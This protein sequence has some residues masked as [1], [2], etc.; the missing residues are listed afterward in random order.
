MSRSVVIDPVTR[1]EGRARVTIRLADD[2]SVEDA[3]VQV[4]DLR[5]FEALCVGRPLSEMPALTARVCGICPVSHSLAAAK[6]GD[7]I[8]GADPPPAARRLRQLVQFA[9]LV[10][11][12]A[13]SFFYLSVPDFVVGHDGDPAERSILGVARALPWLAQDGV[14][15]RRFGQEVIAHAAGQRVHPA[16]AVPGGVARPLPALARERILAELPAAFAAAERALAWW[17]RTSSAL[18]DDA[19]SCGNFESA[20]LSLVGPGGEL[21]LC[22]GR[23]RLVSATGAVLADGVEP[24]RYLDLVG[25]AVEPWT[26]ARQAYL[27]EGGYPAGIY[28]VGPLARLNAASR[29]GTP[30]ADRALDSFRQVAGTPVLSTFHA[31]HARLVELVWALERMEEILADAR[32][33]SPEVRTPP[34]A[35]RPEAV[36]ACEAPR[37]TLFHHYRVDPNGL[38]SWA[39]FIVATG[40]NALAMNRAVRQV[41]ERYMTG[42]ALDSGTVNRVEACVRAFDP[43]LSCA[44]HAFGA[45]WVSVR[46]VASDGR[47]LDEAPQAG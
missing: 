28:R 29:C 22:D 12:H 25:E 2:G 7:A 38:V 32:I 33:L 40:Q 3:R 27:R 30:R 6:A 46:L 23:L 13:L 35:G 43:C 5:G 20:F 18:A 39:N 26:Y 4:T 44:T 14:S 16:Y 19:A 17:S 45:R 1:I 9:Q 24:S 15:L 11:S 41:A 34:G 36:G 21:D 47:V 31:H 10:Q 37:G 42:R 8:L